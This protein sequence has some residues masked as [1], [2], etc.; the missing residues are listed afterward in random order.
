MMLRILFAI[1]LLPGL[2]RR[3]PVE[4]FLYVAEDQGWVYIYDINNN[5]KLVRKFEVQGTGEFKGI[6]ADPVRGKLYLS[7]YVNDQLVCVDLKTEKID[8]TLYIAGYPDSPAITPDGNFIY[9]PKRYSRF[10]DIVDLN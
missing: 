2:T 4:R 6:C 5:H 9:M 8:W 3:V 10:W 1:L 7:S